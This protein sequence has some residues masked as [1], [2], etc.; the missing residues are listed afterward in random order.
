MANEGEPS[1]IELLKV[2]AAGEGE[3]VAKTGAAKVIGSPKFVCAPAFKAK[4]KRPPVKTQIYF[5][6]YFPQTKECPPACSHNS[7]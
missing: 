4:N 5:I 2:G 3:D 6:V 7:D 1:G